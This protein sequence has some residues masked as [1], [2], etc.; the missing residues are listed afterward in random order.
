[1]IDQS[2]LAT[3]LLSSMPLTFNLLAP[4]ATK[5]DLADALLYTLLKEFRGFTE[6]VLFEHSPGRGDPRF[7][8]DYSAFDALTLRRI[9]DNPEAILISRSKAA[10]RNRRNDGLPLIIRP[11]RQRDRAFRLNSQLGGARQSNGN[12]P[13]AP[14]MPHALL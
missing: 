7:T 9:M 2:R 14:R 4:L 8:G 13:Q 6:E 10:P 12:A 11:H 5:R 3:N 1:M